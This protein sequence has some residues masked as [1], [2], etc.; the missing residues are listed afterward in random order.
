MYL[1]IRLAPAFNGTIFG[2]VVA[3][4]GGFTFLAGSAMAISQHNAK[5]VLAYSTIA[6]LGLIICCAGVGTDIAMGAAILLIIFHA[7]SKGLLFLCVGSIEQGI[8]SSDI[9]DMQGLMEKMPYTTVITVIGMISMLLPPFGVLMTRWLAIE[10]AVQLPVVLML[11][12][13]GSAFTVFF[14]AKWMGI[15]LTMSNKT[16]YCKEQ[17][18]ISVRTVMAILLGLVIAACI[19]TTP[20]F[21]SLVP[22]QLTLSVLPSIPFFIILFKN[23]KNHRNIVLKR[24]PDNENFIAK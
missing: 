21:N 9:E 23:I 22:P 17:L 8:G 12:I 15:I 10:A 16:K 1:I 3:V 7:V 24:S 18:S 20:L 2:N 13:L 11:I 4:V 19:L 14:W 6:N 5:H